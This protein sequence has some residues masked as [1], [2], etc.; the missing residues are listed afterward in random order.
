M[1]ARTVLG[2]LALAALLY[3]GTRDDGEVADVPP[4]PPPDP[5]PQPGPVVVDVTPGAVNPANPANIVEWGAWLG[6]MMQ[7]YDISVP[8]IALALIYTARA[9]GANDAFKPL[10]DAEEALDDGA[11]VLYLVNLSA[12]SVRLA[13]ALVGP[14]KL[15]PT[16]PDLETKV[17]KTYAES[18]W[19]KE[20][21]GSCVPRTWGYDYIAPSLDLESPGDYGMSPK[22]WEAVSKVFM[23]LATGKRPW[24]VPW[25][26]V[27]KLPV[28]EM[29]PPVW[30][31]L[32][33][34]EPHL[35]WM[36]AE[37]W[38]STHDAG[39]GTLTTLAR[40]IDFVRAH[41]P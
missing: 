36:A 7:V 30:M 2:V 41:T 32:G 6:S 23:E 29:P 25:E 1:R 22:E 34:P 33:L 19:D 18:P 20:N 38:M 31:N 3:G 5:D 13:Q 24:C 8:D 11:N 39:P 26:A 9:V 40:Y 14:G 21:E 27:E 17:V 15:V 16:G 35:R 4:P 10:T 37:I 28:G 12:A